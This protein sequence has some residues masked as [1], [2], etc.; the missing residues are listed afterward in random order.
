[1]WHSSSSSPRLTSGST[2]QASTPGR[3]NSTGL[4]EAEKHR[5]L[6]EA[7][8]RKHAANG[9]PRAPLTALLQ[10]LFYSTYTV[11]WARSYVMLPDSDYSPSVGPQQVSD[12]LITSTIGIHLVAPPLRVG[13]GNAP[14]L[15]APMPETPV[16]KHREAALPEYKVRVGPE[17]FLSVS[18]KPHA[19]MPSPPHDP[20]R[21]KY[22]CDGR[23]GCGVPPRS[24][25]RHE[26][27]SLL[28]A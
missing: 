1:M 5:W 21:S 16:N 4:G 18:A 8:R 23:F 13:L 17:A 12:S 26:R 10:Y 25:A 15:P 3:E 22:T 7:L 9:E 6:E 2:S 27:G 28:L 24:H 20:H 19:A 14:M 11:L